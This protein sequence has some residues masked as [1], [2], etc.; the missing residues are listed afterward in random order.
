MSIHETFEDQFRAHKARLKMTNRELARLIGRTPRMVGCYGRGSV[1][2]YDEAT[3]IL[4]VLEKATP[5]G[6]VKEKR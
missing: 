5:N 2:D 3:R 6:R 4:A 1:P